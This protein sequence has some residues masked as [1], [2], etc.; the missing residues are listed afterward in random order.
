MIAIEE[1][2]LAERTTQAKRASRLATSG[3]GS[4][5]DAQEKNA[6][7]RAAKAQVAWAKAKRTGAVADVAQAEAGLLEAEADRIITET[8]LGKSQAQLSS[9]LASQQQ[10]EA[11]LGVPGDK[12]VRV[13][14]AKSILARAQL[15]LTRCKVRAPRSGWI[16]NLFLQP[17]DFAQPGVAMIT[18]VDKESLRVSGFFKETQL[19]HIKPGDRAV[20]TLMGHSSRPIE[21]VVE[22]IGRAISPPRIANVEGTSAMVPSVAP[23]YDWIR[24]AQRVPVRIRFKEVPD[25]IVLISGTT[26]SVAIKPSE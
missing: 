23:S 4:V 1:A 14:A 10:V 26:A 18:L 12:N 5:E 21:G 3:A 16:T 15:D 22:S 9:A 20:I 24:L 17:G 11:T 6:L 13:R 7:A 19:E 2:R 8:G 25:D